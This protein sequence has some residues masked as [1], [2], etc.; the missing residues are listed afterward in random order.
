M[1]EMIK[2]IVNEL[3]ELA[4]FIGKEKMKMLMLTKRKCVEW[5]A[6]KL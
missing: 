6:E 1:N 2:N 3:F 5:L 4:A